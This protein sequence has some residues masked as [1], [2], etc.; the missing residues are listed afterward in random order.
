MAE[1]VIHCMEEPVIQIVRTFFL[2]NKR[3]FR[4]YDWIIN[5]DDVYVIQSYLQSTFGCTHHNRRLGI[6]SCRANQ[7]HHTRRI[8]LHKLLA[9]HFSVSIQP[10]VLDHDSQC[11]RLIKIGRCKIILVVRLLVAIPIVKADIIGI[12]IVGLEPLVKVILLFL[13]LRIENTLRI[14]TIV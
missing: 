14:K 7:L 13:I 10:N 9:H 2:V 11:L 3:T 5:V 6:I 8:G 1:L 12:H 4:I